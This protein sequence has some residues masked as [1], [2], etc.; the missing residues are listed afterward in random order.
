[1]ASY[2]QSD[3]PSIKYTSPPTVMTIL[4][5]TPTEGAIAQACPAIG[6]GLSSLLPAMMPP[7]S[8]SPSSA[9]G[10]YQAR[11][12]STRQSLH[13]RC[14]AY[15]PE[16]HYREQHRK[17]RLRRILRHGGFTTPHSQ[18]TLSPL[19]ISLQSASTLLRCLP[20]PVTRQPATTPMLLISA[21]APSPAQ[22]PGISLTCLTAFSA[23]STSIL[24]PPSPSVRTWSSKVPRPSLVIS[25]GLMVNGS[26]GHLVYFT[27][28]RDDTIRGDTDGGGSSSGSPADWGWIEFTPSSDDAS[29]ISFAVIRFGGYSIRTLPTRKSLHPRCF[30]YHPEQHYRE[31]HRKRRLRRILRHGSFTPLIH[32]QLLHH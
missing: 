5:A 22:S 4:A 8:L 24:A 29:T 3:H 20:S 12:I 21:A 26:P 13:P 1:M 30:T 14:F 32:K 15:H 6:A 9:I 17:R 25:G 18:T 27:S 19:T 31:Q 10:G 2:R 23:R 11:T 28:Y 16:L 7:L